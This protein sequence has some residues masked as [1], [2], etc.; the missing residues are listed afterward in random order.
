M[1]KYICSSTLLFMTI[2]I[3]N[4]CQS[5]KKSFESKD[6]DKVITLFLKENNFDDNE[7]S[8]FE[9]SYNAAF[10][11]DKQQVLLL[12]SINN[13]ERWEEIFNLY[14]KINNRQNEV[15]RLL[16]L[17]YTNGEE[18]KI[19]TFNF[20]NVLE[21]SK[22]NA[23]QYYYDQGLKLYNS[24]KKS[25]IRESVDYFTA[26]TKFFINYKDVNELI[27]QAKNKGKNHVLILIDKNPTLLVPPAF[28][29]QILN[30]LKITKNNTW[31]EIENYKNS[32]KEYDYV[33][34]LNIYDIQVSPDILKE[35]N[36]SEEKT[37]ADGW[38]YVLDDRGNVKKDSLGN[39]IKVQKY[40]K[41]SC[42]VRE[43]R[44]SKTAQ[45]F[46]DATIYNASTRQIQKQDRCT[47]NTA[48]NYS[49][50]QYN[51]NRDALSS[52]TLSKL[53]IPP[54][55]FPSSLD[56]VGQSATE[57]T[58]CY[59]DFINKNYSLFSYTAP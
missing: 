49:Y 55:M 28:E 47:G 35:Y 16:P 22:L 30:N 29:Q 23:A 5:I 21:E 17:H 43:T 3:F 32:N 24:G 12:K 39:D 8:M 36:F 44:M 11:R 19:E 54:T 37:I 7:L 42:Q 56:M 59:S 40:K 38:Q 33:V 34:K 20:G 58:R 48:F 10:E 52:S 4:S 18:A 27:E 15:L 2:V 26:S 25:A 50:Y 57:I 31:V 51:G 9:Q 6:Y 53:N 13:G 46:S 41:I 14:T 1:M 45:V